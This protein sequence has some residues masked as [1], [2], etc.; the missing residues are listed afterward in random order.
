[1][2][3]PAVFLDRDGTII[4]ESDYLRRPEQVRLLPH[5]ADALHRLQEAGFALVVVTNQSGV[6]RGLLTEVDLAQ[7]HDLLRS[8]LARRGVQLD[9]VYYCPHHPEAARPEYR[10]TCTCRK[11]S[12]GLLL[13]AAEHLDLD[14]AHSFAVGDSARD[15]A[16][17]RA[18]GCRTVLVRTGYG[19]RTEAEA[20]PDLP[21]DHIADSISDAADWILSQAGYRA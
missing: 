3:R 19:R 21:A 8:R 4:R 2:G 20:G 1:M 5:A 9:A 7:V 10:R 12:P 6:A 17:G 18:A 14:L 13:Q 11:P 15:L 16:A